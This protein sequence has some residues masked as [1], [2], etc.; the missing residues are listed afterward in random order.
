[1]YE[2]TLQDVE[3]LGTAWCLARFAA[4]VTPSPRP[5]ATIS[6]QEARAGRPGC[7]LADLV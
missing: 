3:H 1:V 4:A 2:A 7:F 6:P 5:K